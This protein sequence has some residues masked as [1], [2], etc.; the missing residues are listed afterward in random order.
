M[1]THR[2]IYQVGINLLANFAQG[3]AGIALLPLTT[4]ILGPAEYGVYGMALVM[5]NLSVAL[6]EVG[7]PLTL[8]NR[9][10]GLDRQEAR[11]M[12]SSLL[13]VALGTSASIAFALTLVWPL[14][15]SA[16]QLL[17]SL[18]AT[19]FVILI[20]LIPA[21]VLW[22]LLK[23]ILVVQGRSHWVAIAVI[24]QSVMVFS[25]VLLSLFK[26]GQGQ[27]ALF[28]GNICGVLACLGLAFYLLWPMLIVRPSHRWI[29]D[30]RKLAPAAWL[31]SIAE[32]V[33]SFTES[34]SISNAV[35]AVGLGNYNHARLYQNLAM[36]GTNSFAT[37]VWPHALH[38]AKS[39]SPDFKRLG[40]V[41]DVVYLGLAF[42]GVSFVFFGDQIV[43]LLTNG[44]FQE[45]AGWVPYLII[46]VL[47]QNAGKPV[48]ATI[49]G[50][51]AGNAFS[52]I[53]IVTNVFA[54]GLLLYFV[55]RYGVSAAIAVGIAQILVQR[56]FLQFV[57]I[58][59]RP[60]PFQDRFVAMG[61][62]LIG[63]LA[64]ANEQLQ[65]S[66]DMRVFAYAIICLGL[67]LLAFLVSFRYVQETAFTY[68]RKTPR[69]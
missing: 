42:I 61:T 53:K 22:G 33:F 51:G 63:S 58:K 64:V 21:Q 16:N 25:V 17:A 12:L 30:V 38:Q 10:P 1:S 5:V 40:I 50:N 65:M 29:T 68:L 39:E 35:G 13:W 36:Q 62:V 7:L 9:L 69:R 66:V 45:A 44:K 59:I 55:P 67:F 14:I 6:C 32:N 46:Y 26:L 3:F 48:T 4:K 8:Y 23:T 31:S 18:D 47:I 49:L 37:V 19:E 27:S 54:I 15:A 2:R 28:I 41:W 43:A 57:A 24:L 56:M 52:R 20:T 34:Q 60:V 11:S